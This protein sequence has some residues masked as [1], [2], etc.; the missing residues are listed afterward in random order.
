MTDPAA[1]ASPDTLRVAN[2]EFALTLNL[3]QTA[4]FNLKISGVASDDSAVQLEPTALI[5]RLFALA[6]MDS[7]VSGQ[8]E[9][10]L[11]SRFTARRILEQA[12][13]AHD[14][15]YDQYLSEQMHIAGASWEQQRA[16]AN[17]KNLEWR[18]ILKNSQTNAELL[19]DLITIVEKV[20]IRRIERA[21]MLLHKLSSLLDADKI[22]R[23]AS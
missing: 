17:T 14:V 19:E 9:L 2:G 11:R 13:F 16:T 5:D 22:L 12:R 10:L 23:S 8:Y 3:L 6:R 1:P 7:F 20:Y 21:S 4:V 15:L 18:W